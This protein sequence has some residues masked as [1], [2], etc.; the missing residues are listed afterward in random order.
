M[1]QLFITGQ[2][3]YSPRW[4][5]AFPEA[6][7]AEFGQAELPRGEAVIWLLLSGA[8]WPDQLRQLVGRGYVVVMTLDEQ[9]QQARQALALGAVGYIHALAVAEVLRRVSDV[10]ASGGLWVGA[11]LMRQL[12]VDGAGSPD[13]IPDYSISLAPLTPK[14]RQVAR[15]VA[16][17]K[18]N[19]EIAKD[20]A[21][22]ERTVKTHL[23]HIF[24]K[25]SVRDRLQLALL[26]TGNPPLPTNG[27]LTATR[28]H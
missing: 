9:P 16:T 26:L 28:E 20:L 6:R 23:S 13:Q 17:G 18:T 22:T 10:V 7:I 5:E 11:E 3:V 15:A 12:V 27:P 19:K 2:E 14:E 4:L 8:H 1:E 21:I 24:A 25:L